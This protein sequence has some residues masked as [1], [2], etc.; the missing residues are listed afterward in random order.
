M[1]IDIETFETHLNLSEYFTVECEIKIH[2]RLMKR[3][4]FS[5]TPHADLERLALVNRTQAGFEFSVL[6]CELS[7]ADEVA[8]LLSSI[9]V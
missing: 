1:Q 7:T 8:E 3:Y 5:R 9:P 6:A 2:Q 4:T